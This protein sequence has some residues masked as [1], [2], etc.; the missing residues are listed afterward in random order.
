VPLALA[1]DTNGSIRVPSSFCGVWGLKPTFGRLSRAGT[2][3]FVSTLDHVGPIAHGVH[4]LALSYDAMQACDPR[5]A[6]CIVRSVEPVTPQLEDD[7]QGISVAR[8]TGYFED[9]ADAGVIEIVEEAATALGTSREIEIPGAA[10]ARAAAVVITA[11]E[12]GELHLA[13]LRTRGHD[14][15]PL[16]VDRLRAATLVPAEWYVRARQVRAQ[17]T[18]AALRAFDTVDVILA[19]A[20]PSVAPRIG[21]E[22]MLLRGREL[23]ARASAGLLTQPLSC[24]GLPV[25]CAPVGDREGLPVGMQIVARPWREDLC[26]RVAR[27]LERR[28]VARARL[29]A[30]PR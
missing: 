13:N 14:Y 1:S 23:P 9:N 11:A 18:E 2:F 3:P 19:P 8:A 28:G 17:C 29:T 24:V 12:A 16:V 15:G 6:T 20:T 5:D 27:A 26:F 10:L 25:I 7:L 21:Q 22:T 4:A 30:R